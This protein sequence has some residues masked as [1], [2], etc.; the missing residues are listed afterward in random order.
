MLAVAVDVHG[1]TCQFLVAHGATGP[2]PEL[3]GAPR[4]ERVAVSK[5][6]F[7]HRSSTGSGRDFVQLAVV[8]RRI[9]AQLR[10]QVRSG[11]PLV[12]L[13]RLRSHDQA[14]APRSG[15]N[16]LGGNRPGRGSLLP[17]SEGLRRQ[18]PRSGVGH[19]NVEDPCRRTAC[20]GPAGGA[21]SPQI[22]VAAP[23]R[24]LSGGA[25]LEHTGTADLDRRSES[26]GALTTWSFGIGSLDRVSPTSRATQIEP[27]PFRLWLCRRLFLPLPSS[28]RTC[29]EGR[30]AGKERVPP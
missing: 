10:C 8:S 12:K 6:H 9:G 2:G 5:C 7:G 21:S 3:R 4:P 22:W 18:S 23:R 11:S 29:L 14:T 24:E 15:G 16:V 20:Q 13:G 19:A 30:G 1:N 27:Q 28:S 25:V 26:I 17:S